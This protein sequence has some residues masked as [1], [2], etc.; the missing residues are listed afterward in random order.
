MDYLQILIH[1]LKGLLLG[2]KKVYF[3]SLLRLIW[4]LLVL[5]LKDTIH[6]ILEK[7]AIFKF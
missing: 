1:T 5:L 2:K 7:N 4:E 3:F 6:V